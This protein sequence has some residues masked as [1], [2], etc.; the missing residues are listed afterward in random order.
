MNQRRQLIVS[1]TAL[2]LC[3]WG[4]AS[5]MPSE[6]M[7]AMQAIV[8]TSIVNTGRVYF[9]LPPLVE[10]G[11]LVAVKFSVDSPMTP[12]NYVRAIHI[13]SEANPSANVVSC[14]FT[15]L[16]GKAEAST[17][18]RLADSQRVW[19]LAQM[20]DGSF[21]RTSVDTVITLSACTEMV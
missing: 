17:R 10:S 2:S 5:A 18:I 3:P 21:W 13:I 19:A 15:P 11:N 6:A 12:T 16:S 7:Q 1:L 8:G 14:Y 9:E 4:S 20:S